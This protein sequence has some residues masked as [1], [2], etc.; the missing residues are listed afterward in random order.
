M[1][2]KNHVSF[3]LE[4]LFFLHSPYNLK[5][6]YREGLSIHAANIGILFETSKCLTFFDDTRKSILYE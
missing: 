6:T 4:I 2:K 5:K 3:F 1:C